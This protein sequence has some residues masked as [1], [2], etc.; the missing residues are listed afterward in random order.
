MARIGGVNLEIVAYKKYVDLKLEHPYY[1]EGSPDY[2]IALFRL[3]EAARG[4]EI[5]TIGL[6]ETHG[7]NLSFSTLQIAGFGS[8]WTGGA[9]MSD[10][11][12]QI[13]VQLVSNYE[14]QLHYSQKKITESM[15]CVKSWDHFDPK[16]CY[17][18]TGGPLTMVDHLNRVVQL[19]IASFSKKGC[20]LHLPMVYTKT[21]VY[22]NWISSTI[23]K[24]A[25]YLYG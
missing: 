14:C 17:G 19:G 7:R 1:K 2:D 16:E 9:K 4:P 22:A 8:R 15:F 23:K 12:L 25:Q 5:G 6:S 21:S 3:P 24:N 18:D 20:Q 10:R 11:L 13:N